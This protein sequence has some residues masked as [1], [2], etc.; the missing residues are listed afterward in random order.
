MLG[1]IRFAQYPFCF[2]FSSDHRSWRQV[3]QVVQGSPDPR[4]PGSPGDVDL[5]KGPEAPGQ[6]PPES[7][8]GNRPPGHA[9]TP[10]CSGKLRLKLSTI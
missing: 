8:H 9:Q 7:L 6:L 2:Y 1:A 3:L 4:E 10:A 5:R